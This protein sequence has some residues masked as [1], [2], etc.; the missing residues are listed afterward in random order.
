MPESSPSTP[1][2]TNVSPS[3]YVELCC[4]TNYSFLEAASH[5][6]E[7]VARAARLGHASLAITDVNSLAGVVRAHAASRELRGEGGWGVVCGARLR[8]EDS[9]P[10]VVWVPDRESY[11]A[12]CR[13]LTLGRRRAGKGECRLWWRDLEEAGGGLLAGVLLHRLLP[14]GAMGSEVRGDVVS[15]LER[16]AG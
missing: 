3:G 9:P 12:L 7:L 5:P 13:L 2:G 11:A 16:F 6:E 15:F 1:R 10:V 8:F 4:R 14:G